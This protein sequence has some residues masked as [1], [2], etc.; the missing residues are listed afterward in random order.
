MKRSMQ[1]LVLL[2]LAL[3]CWSTQLDAQRHGGGLAA[4]GQARA[5]VNA[6]AGMAARPAVNRPV[7]VD[8]SRTV[9]RNV[10]RD[11]HVDREIDVN[12]HGG[13]YD[14]HDG[15]CHHPVA[16]VAAINAANSVARAANAV[17]V[18]AV[19]STLPAYC[20]VVVQNGVTYQNCGGTWY[21]PQFYGTE[22]AYVVVAPPE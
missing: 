16:T 3:L 20:E 14:D 4:R 2:T 19:A 12:A 8:R 17:A 9:N 13:W 18:G 6:R 10:N 15:C 22:T 7:N 1:L 11:I 5:S 21:Q